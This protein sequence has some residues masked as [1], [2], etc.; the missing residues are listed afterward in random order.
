M[1]ELF[2][3]DA[4]SLAVGEARCSRLLCGA[5]VLPLSYLYCA[6]LYSQAR[7]PV[8]VHGLSDRDPSPPLPCRIYIRC[9]FRVHLTGR[10]GST[11]VI[12]STSRH[13][14]EGHERVGGRAGG[15]SS[16]GVVATQTLAHLCAMLLRWLSVRWLLVRA[17]DAGVLCPGYSVGTVSGV[18]IRSGTS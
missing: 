2:H 1:Y 12:R 15:R 11:S 13:R 5:Q 4:R 7:C 16:V 10:G 14:T 6:S 8:Q 3:R 9:M 18:L 17:V